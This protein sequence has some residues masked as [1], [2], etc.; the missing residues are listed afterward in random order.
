MNCCTFLL[1][2]LLCTDSAVV[3]LSFLLEE[4]PTASLGYSAIFLTFRSLCN[5][6]KSWTTRV[7]FYGK[8]YCDGDVITVVIVLVSGSIGGPAGTCGTIDVFVPYRL[9]MA[10]SS[11]LGAELLTL[12]LL[13]IGIELVWVYS[14]RSLSLISPS[15]PIAP[16]ASPPAPPN[17]FPT[18][19]MAAVAATLRAR[20]SVGTCTG[21][22]EGAML[23]WRGLRRGC[24]C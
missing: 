16:A 19:F 17:S 14:T 8:A 22:L 13:K 11:P 20:G 6:Y 10:V 23:R 12:A 21:W 7:D 9:L 18:S 24:C 4:W 15:T 2:T 1:Y 5:P 3:A